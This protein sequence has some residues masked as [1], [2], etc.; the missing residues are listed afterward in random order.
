MLHD[1]EGIMWSEI[2]KTGE[3]GYCVIS[4]THGLYKAKPNE[5]TSQSRNRD[6]DTKNTQLTVRGEGAGG[7]EGRQ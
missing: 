4:F 1:L 3:D 5:Q 6:A 7:E 2:S